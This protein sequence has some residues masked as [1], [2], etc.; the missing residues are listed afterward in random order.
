M[1]DTE[2][3]YRKPAPPCAVAERAEPT[4]LERFLAWLL[5]ALLFSSWRWYRRASG[6]RWARVYL[7]DSG[8]WSYCGWR[9]VP[10]CYTH[11]A[12]KPLLYHTCGAGNC[13][14]ENYGS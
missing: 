3:P 11:T 1:S 9:R 2:T 14:C 7:S 13:L 8:Q 4:R 12:E 5:P 6:G 10:F